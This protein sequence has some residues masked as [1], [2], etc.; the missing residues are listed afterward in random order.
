MNLV[1]KNIRRDIDQLLQ[2][3]GSFWREKDGTLDVPQ[4]CSLVMKT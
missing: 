4:M 1:Q 2:G 3:N